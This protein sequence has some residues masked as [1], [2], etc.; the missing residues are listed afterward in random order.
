MF[1]YA[2]ISGY[3]RSGCG[4]KAVNLFL[5]LL[6]QGIRCE[7]GC[8]VT[9]LDGC[10]ECKNLDLGVQL[11]GFV[12]KPA[13]KVLDSFSSKNI[14]LFNAILV[15]FMETNRADD[16]DAMV[17]FRQLRLGGMKPDFVT[18][19]WLLNLSVNQACLV[20]GKSLHSYTIKMGFEADLRV[21]NALITMYA[22]C[23]SIEDACQMFNGMNGHDSVSLNA[24][25]SAYSIH[26]LG[27]KA[28]MLF[29]EMKRE[30]FAPDEITILALL[31]ACSY[32]GL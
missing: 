21:S 13:K 1:F 29:E 2:L 17:L 25:V 11:H 23:G 19:S 26:G 15:G 22:K 31:Q 32:T 28:L 24:M 16:E 10:S 20:K 7:S 3:V 8:L 5:E 6:D 27:K 9:V 4:E 30:G 12:I 14:A 18:F